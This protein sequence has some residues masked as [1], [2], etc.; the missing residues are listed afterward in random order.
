MGT[1]ELASICP[2]ADR[3]NGR[4]VA[5]YGGLSDEVKVCIGGGAN[6]AM[7]VKGAYSSRRAPAEI[8]LSHSWTKMGQYLA[9]V[10][11]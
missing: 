9:S 5:S 11:T 3:C 8:R 6:R 7:A 4:V 1:L 2:L 10:S